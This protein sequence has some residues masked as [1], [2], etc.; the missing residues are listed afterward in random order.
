M[1]RTWSTW[2]AVLLLATMMGAGALAPGSAMATTAL[3]FSDA[4]LAEK[5][6]VIVLA[7]VTGQVTF[8]GRDGLPYTDTTLTVE[9][10][11]HGA[12]RVGAQLKVRQIGGTVEGVTRFVPGDAVL[13]LG[14][15]SV[16]FLA[17]R[18][19]DEDVLYL[20]QLAQSVLEV[21]AEDAQGDLILGREF[22][23][24]TFYDPLTN[25]GQVY[26][27]DTFEPLTLSQLTKIVEE[28]AR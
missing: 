18:T 8:V 13:D 2:A 21:V 22:H 24:L 4:Q 9:R 23:G 5:S 6:D 10:V 12:V 28:A 7:E 19:P 17:D 14:E 20:T 11:L 25:G 27:V 1:R 3:H 16:F 26:V 15:R